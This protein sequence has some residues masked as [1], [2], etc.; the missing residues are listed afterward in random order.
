[1]PPADD[2]LTR[3]RHLHDEVDQLF[4][5]LM[6]VRGGSTAAR[7]LTDV[8]LTDGPPTLNVTVDV[9][10]LDPHTLEVVLDGDVLSVRGARHRRDE[11]GRRVY[12]HAEI[13]WGPFERRIRIATPVDP[14][15]ATVAYEQGL[16]QIA[17][18]LATRPVLTRVLIGARIP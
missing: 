6:V 17:L 12:H 10:G 15:A 14:G 8:Y 1:M 7:V 9:A 4:A 11:A 13:D 3:F 2:R 18:P 16:L 5:D